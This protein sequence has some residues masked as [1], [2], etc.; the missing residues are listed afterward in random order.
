[1]RILSRTDFTRPGDVCHVQYVGHNKYLTYGEW[2]YVHLL[3]NEKQVGVCLYNNPTIKCN[4]GVQFSMGKF[5]IKEEDNVSQLNV[6]HLED[7]SPEDLAKLMDEARR[8]VEEENIAK[9]AA[10]IYGIK[11]K[12]LVEQTVQEIG[13]AIGLKHGPEITKLRANFV[14]M[15]NYMLMLCINR[16]GNSNTKIHT[17]KEWTIFKNICKSIK[18]STIKGVNQNV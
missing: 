10:A 12:E 1:M 7:L 13:K 3:N 8:K 17:D 11:K 2:Y 16:K 9:D 15:S 18:E 4:Y 14:T 5:L 6:I